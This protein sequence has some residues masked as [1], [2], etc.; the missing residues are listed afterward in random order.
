[1]IEQNAAYWM[2]VCVVGFL[3]VTIIV[4]C[5]FIAVYDHLIEYDGRD[6]IYE[7]ERKRLEAERKRTRS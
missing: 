2:A 6:E 7:A 5:L 1:M 3:L 4:V